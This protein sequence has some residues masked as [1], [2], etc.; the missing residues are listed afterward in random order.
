MRL[1]FEH[2]PVHRPIP[3]WH[4]GRPQLAG[5]GNLLHRPAAGKLRT[6]T[7]EPGWRTTG[8]TNMR[9][10]VSMSGANQQ[11]T[12]MYLDVAT[13]IDPGVNTL[14]D[15]PSQ[16]N[17][18]KHQEAIRQSYGSTA[19]LEGPTPSSARRDQM[20]TRPATPR[21]TDGSDAGN[22]QPSRFHPIQSCD[23]ITSDTSGSSRVGQTGLPITA[24]RNVERLN[25]ASVQR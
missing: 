5:K 6:N 3:R 7:T 17:R 20:A 16:A 1:G 4:S 25:R 11:K 12:A 21:Q 2:R 9:E 22:H 15:A 19:L 8:L 24:G 14:L 23:R 10:E 18:W 13:V